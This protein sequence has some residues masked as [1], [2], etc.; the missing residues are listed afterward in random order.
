MKL[1]ALLVPL[2]AGWACARPLSASSERTSPAPAAVIA[3][4]DLTAGAGAAAYMTAPQPGGVVGGSVAE[5]L[6]AELVAVLRARG[7]EPAADGAL[8]A[9]AHWF[10]LES[11]EGRSRPASVSE[12]VAHHFGFPGGLLGLV[13]AEEG[14][15]AARWREL[16]TQT[17]VNI[18]IN[19]YGV[20]ATNA[21]AVAIAIGTIEA[22]FRPIARRLSPG[23]S[24][25]LSGEIG[26]RFDRANVFLTRTDGKVRE[27]RMRVRRVEADL[28]FPVAGVY[29]LEVMG[30]GRTG[31]VIVLNVPVYVG[32]PEP[33]LG[34]GRSEV[35]GPALGTAAAE[36]RMFELL[37]QARAQAG[38]G[39][40]LADA[41]LRDIALGHSQDMARAHFVAHV[42]PSNGTL[43]DRLK[44]AGVKLAAGGENIARAANPEA[45]HEDLMSSP[46]HRVNMLGP[47][48]THVGIA[49]VPDGDQIL[50]T[51]VFG[52]RVDPAALRITADQALLAV[53]TLR[54]SRGLPPVANDPAR[55]AA[56]EA[57]IRAYI[58]GGA[59]AAFKETTTALE[60]EI[61][62]RKIPFTPGCVH[63]FETAD[64]DQLDQIPGALDPRLHAIGL[65]T[66]TRSEGGRTS[67]VVVVLTAGI[68]CQ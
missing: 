36:A 38:I 8:A 20:F 19:R 26:P 52:R 24:L 67:L 1:A 28:G 39:P 32:V 56:A 61:A 35:V 7:A 60:R 49:I 50:A 53:A 15:A 27:N 59:A 5:N 14:P 25:H 42:S 21:G 64:P 4:P 23:Q 30:D 13:A 3:Q 46:G 37:N 48:F 66:S 11:Q 31:P 33:D 16:L 18:P 9:T 62:A 43:D 68:K 41:E 10:L 34:P 40:L 2:L 29:Q 51:L 44:R 12:N 47:R 58:T 63:V 54:R 45:A 57:G 22:E 55:R 6:A 17:P 65:A